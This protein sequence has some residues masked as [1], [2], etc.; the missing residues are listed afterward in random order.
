LFAGLVVSGVALP[1]SL[2]I[3]LASDVP[4]MLGV[5]AA[6]IPGIIS[7]LLG[8]SSVGVTGPAVVLAVL[9]GQIVF[10]YGVPGLLF[11]TLLAGVMQIASGTL[12]FGAFLRLVPIGVIHGFTA[13]VGI[14][15]LIG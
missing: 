3:A 5:V 6:V 12:G 14:I 10:M 8:G 2:A 7:A 1:L 4:P 13:G 9:V 15:I 11:T